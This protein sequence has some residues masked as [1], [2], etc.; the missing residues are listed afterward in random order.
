VFG[1]PFVSQT[2]SITGLA[3]AVGGGVAA[4]GGTEVRGTP[5]GDCVVGAPHPIDKV[6]TRLTSHIVL[7]RFLYFIITFFQIEPFV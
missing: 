6:M 1:I 2:F 5:V 7:N 3:G 4:V